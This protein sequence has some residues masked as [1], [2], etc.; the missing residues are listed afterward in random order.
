[1]DD[2]LEVLLVEDNPTDARLVRELLRDADP[3]SRAFRL[4]HVTRLTHALERLAQGRVDVVLLDLHLPDSNGVETLARI[5][6][7]APDVA[8]VVHTGLN[9]DALAIEAVRRGAQDYLTKGEVDGHR[10]AQVLRHAAARR[11]VERVRTRAVSLAAHELRGPLTPIQSLLQMLLASELGTLSDE[12]RAAAQVVMRN[13]ARMAGLVQDLADAAR[14]Q[15]GTLAM[16]AQEVPLSALVEEAAASFAEPARQ[17]GLDLRVDVEPGMQA[18]ADPR[19]TTQAMFNL[20]S[21]AVK[22]TPSPGRISVTADADHGL[23]RIEV[24]D[25]GVGLTGEQ[26]AGLFRPFGQV[27]GTPQEAAAGMGLGLYLSRM[28]AE[29]QGGRLWAAS[30][31]PGQGTTFTLEVPLLAPRAEAPEPEAPEAA[32]AH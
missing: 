6:L 7:K 1:M 27:H 19:R 28:L 13:V 21:N 9:D 8:V 3:G 32:P 29:R 17:A 22:F 15:E 26:L 25:S 18:W 20:L 31:G 16:R 10:L 5:Q 4:E 2:P 12:Q 24:R 23:A 14:I 30:A 11:S